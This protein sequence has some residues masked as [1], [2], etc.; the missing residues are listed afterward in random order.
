VSAT[1]PLL[2]CVVKYCKYN[3]SVNNTTLYFIYN[4]NNILS[5]RHVSTFIWSSSEPLGKQIRELSIFQCIVEFCSYLVSVFLSWTNFQGSCFCIYYFSGS[6][7]LCFSL[8]ATFQVFKNRNKIGTKFHNALKYR[9]LSDL[10]SQRSWRWPNKGQN[11]SSWQ[12]TIFILYKIKCCVIDWHVV[13]IC[14]NT[15]GSKTLQK[16]CKV[17]VQNSSWWWT[18]YLFETCRG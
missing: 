3:V 14:Y 16:Y 1:R 7:V 12:Y 17:P 9:K 6:V 11:M 18:I 5:G 4:K 13:F 10:F 2:R 15:L 8:F